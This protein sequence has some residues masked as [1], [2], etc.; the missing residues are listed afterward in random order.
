MIN[1]SEINEND[2]VKI[3]V[4]ED[5][6]E[7]EMYGV[8]GMNTGLTL[9]VRYLNPTCTLYK[10]AC[11]Y[12]LDDGDML[13]APYESVMEHYP[14]CTNF[15]DLEMKKVGTDLFAFYSEIDMDDTDSELYEDGNTTSEMGSFIVS[16]TDMEGGSTPPPDHASVD[17][18]W[19]E[20]N[21]STSGGKHF[22]NTI[23]RIEAEI[24]HLSS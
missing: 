2:I 17:R 10:S 18:Q 12:K 15:E 19:S 4:N 13:P 8:V 9:G 6:L 20:W 21:P 7:D 11:V 1:H 22:K 24:R 16:D 3:L 23:D 5:G 14:S